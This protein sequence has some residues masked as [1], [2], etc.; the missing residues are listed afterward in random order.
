VALRESHNVVLQHLPVD[1]LNAESHLR[2]LIDEDHLTVGGRQDFT[3][4]LAHERFLLQDVIENAVHF[5]K[6][7]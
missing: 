1:G 6:I 4:G 3:L 5:L 7:T 2:L